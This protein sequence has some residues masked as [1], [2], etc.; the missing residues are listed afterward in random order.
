MSDLKMAILFCNDRKVVQF[1][2]QKTFYRLFFNFLIFSKPVRNR[3]NRF[4]EPVHGKPV[5]KCQKFKKEYFCIN[6]FKPV[7]NRF[8]IFEPD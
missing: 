3:F 6:R 2:F 5:Q 1:D 8:I 7:F 4:F